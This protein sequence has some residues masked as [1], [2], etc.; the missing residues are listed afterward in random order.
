[1][2]YLYTLILISITSYLYSQT[3]QGDSLRRSILL[4]EIE[5]SESYSDDFKCTVAQ[6]VQ[7]IQKKEI[8]ILMSRSTADILTQSG[9]IFIQSSQFGGG[10]PVI[11]GF[12]ASR[13]LLVIDGI[14]MNNLIYRSGHLQSIITSDPLSMERIEIL[15]GPSS[16]LFGSDALGGVI[17]MH[18]IK[19]EFSD[20]SLLLKT[21]SS[22]SYQTASS[23][24]TGHLD[25]TLSSRRLASLT[26]I[27]YSSFGDLKSGR[28]INP[29]YG[30]PYGDRYFYVHRING[31]DSVLVN[32][33]PHVQ[34]PSG[35]SQYNFIQKFI[36]SRH[37]K[38]IHS[39]NLYYTTSTDIPRYDRLIDYSKD[40]PRYA[41]WYYGPQNHF[42]TAY[43]FSAKPDGFFN[44]VVANINYQ[45]VEES[46]H[47]RRFKSNS[48]QHRIEKVNVLN[49]GF[50][51]QHISQSNVFKIGIDASINSLN[52]EAFQENIVTGVKALLD[53]R[54]PDG[55]NNMSSEAIYLAHTLRFN[56]RYTLVDGFR[57]GFASLYSSFDVNYFELPV[58]HVRQHNV[59]YAG[60][61]GIIYRPSERWKLSFLTST[62]FRV[63]NVDDLSKIFESAPGDLIVPNEK[64]RPEKS[65]NLELGLA[66]LIKK[67]FVFEFTIYRIY[68]LDAIVT[69]PFSFQGRDSVLYE[70]TMSKVLA[71]QNM[72]S[73]KI[74]GFST[75]IKWQLIKE[76][77]IESTADYAYGRIHTDSADY[78]LDHIPPFHAQ[79]QCTYTNKKTSLVFFVNFNG[80]KRLKDYYLN[81]EDNEQYAT[82]EG[83]PGWMTLNLRL[84]YHLTASWSFTT[85]IDNFLDTQYRVFS[86]GINAP[87]RNFIS[88]INY[89]FGK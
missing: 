73:A 31:N 42:I 68:L 1:M 39:L 75:K 49:V 38:S 27:T 30:R 6:Q 29:F 83:M 3:P 13:I 84:N 66:T 48:L 2:R 10:S 46:R 19:P 40:S 72:Q 34:V 43:N 12:E 70:G 80:W 59:T 25:L 81:G 89:K 47:S 41:Q 44:Y 16:T 28:N 53:T 54:Y 7:S 63:P 50:S 69:A 76:F 24:F 22:S 88:S 5:I 33:N 20:S 4:G 77:S 74:D 65:V 23:G 45:F 57:L 82:P 52:S 15:Y 35:Y 32:R 61:V 21:N 58:K 79:V 85:G 60:N 51:A 71:N 11:R 55:E 56:D 78:P 17:H 86:S 62:G 37:G 26:S 14:R 64:L 9:G 87:G 18:T 67:N 8:D 36:L